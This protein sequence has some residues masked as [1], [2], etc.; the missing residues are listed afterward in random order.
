LLRH[1]RKASGSFDEAEQDSL[2]YGVEEGIAVLP[3]KDCGANGCAIGNRS[4]N[5]EWGYI[6]A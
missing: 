1:Q 6:A 3:D 4:R 5:R 2:P